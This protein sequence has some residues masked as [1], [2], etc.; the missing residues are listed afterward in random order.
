MKASQVLLA[1]LLLAAALIGA[2]RWFGSDAPGAALAAS[3]H[4]A[5]ESRAATG[6]SIEPA[7]PSEFEARSE[8]AASDPRASVV[9]GAAPTVDPARR[10]ERALQVVD[11]STG[12]PVAGALVRYES[13]AAGER[14]H[15]HRAMQPASCDAWR[16]EA[17][18]SAVT[19]ADGRVELESERG[20]DCVACVS[21]GELFARAAFKADEEGIKIVK[22]APDATVEVLV[23][24]PD[25][26]PAPNIEVALRRRIHS[27]FNDRRVA[28]TDAEGRANWPHVA[29]EFT[30]GETWPWS[31]AVV[32]LAA[33]EAERPL[34]TRNLPREPLVLRI[35]A[36]GSVEVRVLDLDGKPLEDGQ[37][38]LR[39]DAGT[40]G[41][42]P[43]FWS[44]GEYVGAKLE[45]GRALFEHVRLDEALLATVHTAGA[46]APVRKRFR[47]PRA[48]GER[49][50]VEFALGEDQPVA[51]V[52]LLD[53][54]GAPLTERDVRW[55]LSLTGEFTHS[56]NQGRQRTNARGEASFLLEAQ[57]NAKMQRSLLVALDNGEPFPPQ[58]RLD[59]SRAFA[60]GRHELGELVLRAP[61]L[62]AAG[63][64]LDA[65]G[66]PAAGARV[67]VTELFA[68]RMDQLDQEVDCDGEG[69]FALRGDVRSTR[70][71]VSA[72]T[73]SARSE[74]L[75]CAVGTSDLELTLIEGGRIAGRVL[76][77]TPSAAAALS[78]SVSRVD[79]GYTRTED[80]D[81]GGAFRFEQLDPGEW[82]LAL[83]A[84]GAHQATPVFE[85]TGLHVPAGGECADPRLAEI[86]LRGRVATLSLELVPPLPSD[87]V[88]GVV[89]FTPRPRASAPQQAPIR[90][91]FM[92][93][94]LEVGADAESFDVVVRAT[95]FRVVERTQVRGALRIEL[96]RGPLVRLRAPPELELP[97][98]PQHLKPYLR[99][100]GSE[101]DSLGH[102]QDAVLGA[103]REARVYAPGAGEFEVVWLLETRTESSLTTS[104]IEVQTPQRVRVVEISVEQVIELA[105]PFAEIAEALRE[106]Q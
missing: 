39:V 102:F 72:H 56:T 42:S 12:E 59:L 43:S 13:L 61:P 76:L 19:A 48:W 100:I 18:P 38:E 30:P 37:V 11:A 75:A 5:V 22:L 92:D 63:R 93:H 91:M 58:A 106:R 79:Q 103:D 90:R 89:T 97:A 67:Q 78:V 44:T 34:D 96:T 64:V 36:S 66:A 4:A 83:A 98:P 68:E 101:G 80:L 15:A 95:G 9:A 52:R 32:G 21:H 50:E 73:D 70:V 23:L 74:E 60:V 26:A 88:M 28:R 69:R 29:F 3:P 33:P 77:D 105:P 46:A 1:L 51:I 57:W 53:E 82:K 71:S 99:E 81:A 10:A 65:N 27:S 47:G 41:A 16:S 20:R 55:T 62:I 54:A 94:K 87:R 6:S 49:V 35:G 104:E 2:A 31:V 7:R 14:E 84:K 8:S 25:G 86:D 45:A 85:L 24:G 40:E 17:G